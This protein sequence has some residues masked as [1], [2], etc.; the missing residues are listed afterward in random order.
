MHRNA[1][2]H[3][4]P[5]KGS[6]HLLIAPTYVP[7]IAANW[8]QP[9]FPLT[10]GRR[11]KPGCAHAVEYYS[12]TKG[13][14][15]WCTATCMNLQS[16]VLNERSQSQKTAYYAVPCVPLRKTKLRRWRT[17]Q[18]W[19]VVSGGGGAMM[20]RQ[21][22]KGVCISSVVV[23]TQI[24]TRIKTRRTIYPPKVNLIVFFFLFLNC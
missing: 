4:E 17:E 12:A 23:V 13:M 11:N 16:T 7:G 19:P 24:Y 6:S 22:R 20:K 15:Y 8:K 1:G 14:N 5:P 9:T 3:S 10:G 2:P 18:W 21:L